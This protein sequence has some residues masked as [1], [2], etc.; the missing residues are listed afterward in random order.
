MNLHRGPFSDG[1]PH[2]ADDR[3]EAQTML[4]LTPQLH[5]RGGVGL[6]ET[7]HPHREPFL[8]ASCPWLLAFLWRGLGTLGLLPSL[9]I[10]SQ[11]LCSLRLSALPVLRSIHSPT[12]G[13]FHIPPSGGG[14]K[15]ASLSSS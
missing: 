4:V 5:F 10:Y 6:L 12:L 9:L 14:F 13:E 8:K 1:A 11:P 3:L 2:F 15:S 7:S